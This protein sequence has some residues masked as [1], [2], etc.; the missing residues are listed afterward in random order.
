MKRK[1]LLLLLILISLSLTGATYYISPNGKD[2][3]NGDIS[4]PFFSLNKVWTVIK[5][6]DQVFLRGGTYSF[7]TQQYLRG[8]DGTSV[9]LIRIWAYPGEIPILTKSGNYRTNSGIYFSG[10]Y[11]YFKGL[12]ISGYTQL[13]GGVCAGFSIENSSHNIFE[14]LNY[15]NNGSGMGISQNSTDNL[16][17]NCDFHHNQDPLTP[18]GDQYGNADGFGFDNIP[19]GAV[20]TVWGCRFWWNTDDGI[21]PYGSDGTIII[22]NCWSFYNGYI[23]DTFNKGGNGSGFK[24]GITRADHGNDVLFQIRNCLAYKNRYIGFDQNGAKATTELYNNTSYM[25]G[26]HGFYF[27]DYDRVNILKNNISFKNLNEF[28][29]SNESIL[30]NN[31]FSSNLSVSESDFIGLDGTQLMGNRKADGSLP[32]I[33][34]LH[35]DPGSDLIDAGVDV[36]L[37]YT[38]KAP[39]IGAFELQT[40]SSTPVPTY[41]YSVIENSTP[42]VLEITYNLNLDNQ[43]V[44]ATSS[45]GV[46]VNSVTRTINSV[47]ISGNT[48]QL[49][50][51]SAVKFGDIVTVSYTK[52]VNNPLQ[53]YTGGE[54]SGFS[55]YA[56]TNDCIS[57]IPV[58]SSS[59]VENATPLIIEMTYSLSLA[60]IVPASSV[61]NVQVNSAARTVNSV[62][63]S[64]NK[65][66]LTIASAVKFGDIIA[67]SYTK[68]TNNP[69]QT[70]GGVAAASISSKSVTNNCEDVNKANVPP[71]VV[72]IYS[73]FAYSGFVYE[74]DASG[75][76]DFN[77]DN[78]NYNWT[79]PNNISVSTTNSSRL[80]Y[81]APVVAKS[82]LLEFQVKVSDGSDI[83][84]KSISINIMPYKPTLSKSKITNV[85]TNNFEQSDSPNNA[86]DGNTLTKWSSNGD[87]Q[88]LLFKLG[89]PFK[90]SYVDLAF[91]QGQRYAS[92]FDIYASKDNLTWE[93]IMTSLSSCDFSGDRQVFDFPVL[94]SN[95]EY[96]FL[97][98]VGHGNSLNTSNNI[99]EFSIFG[100]SSK[101]PGSANPEKI[102]LVIYPNPAKDFFY[103]SIDEPVLQPITVRIIDFSGKIEFEYSMVGPGPKNIQIPDNLYSGIYVVEAITSSMKLDAQKLIIK[104]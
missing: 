30:S 58:Y 81:L 33:D 6:G 16:I 78:L 84:S 97:K 68:P 9:N 26:N 48:V 96:S 63:I 39:D 80:E 53:T 101:N 31:T 28:K 90:I 29:V 19:E 1:V 15:H 56:V 76:Y 55:T 41:V 45:F 40:G 37:P 44:P 8:K 75:S 17:L 74:I 88:W 98:Y 69:L 103:V 18:G 27:N 61:F 49:T 51:A 92:Y 14:L 73:Q 57:N 23:P 95:T 64:G 36:G 104:R 102:K 89:E 42:S 4:H 70:P 71:V 66:L 82:Q 93:P 47:Y 10:D 100:S 24:L 54:A 7:D 35:L 11:F 59:V 43:V 50:M 86:I 20:N 91:L 83:V 65:V 79:V 77:N 25:N 38:G 67:I 52:P 21:D 2:S 72:T 99:S 12:D 13:D 5:A 87:N 22:E 34:F 3:N 32:D 60:N 94:N 85:E 46:S 62:S